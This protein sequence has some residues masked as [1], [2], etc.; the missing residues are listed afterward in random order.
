MEKLFLDTECY[1]N[2]FL[3]VLKNEVGK[4][5]S[6]EITP[7]QPLDVRKFYKTIHNKQLI[8]FNSKMYDIPMVAYA[9]T[10]VNNDALKQIDRK[11]VV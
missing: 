10:G 2:Y 4:I 1:P 5:A 3:I 8:G 6:F 9:L 7:K 11:S